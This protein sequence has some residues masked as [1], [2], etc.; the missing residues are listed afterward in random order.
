MK[1]QKK[2][3]QMGVPFMVSSLKERVGVPRNSVS[4]SPDQ[5]SF[6]QV[7]KLLIDFKTVENTKWN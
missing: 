7:K 5:K 1:D 2:G 3:L 6:I 4:Q